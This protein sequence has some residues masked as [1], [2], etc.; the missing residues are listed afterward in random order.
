MAD[1]VTTLAIKDGTATASG[2]SAVSSSTGYSTYHALTGTLAND[3]SSSLSS[4]ST[5]IGNLL[6]GTTISASVDIITGDTNIITGALDKISSSLSYNNLSAANILNN[7]S[8]SLYEISSSINN[9]Y[10]DYY[11]IQKYSNNVTRYTTSNTLIKNGTPQSYLSLSSLRTSLYFYNATNAEV[12]LTIGSTTSYNV[13]GAY[14][15]VI[16]SSG[17]YVSLRENCRLAHGVTGSVNGTTGH[18][19]FTE[20]YRS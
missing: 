6:T 5:N 19:I 2:L 14:T 3:L 9:F 1:T 13:N 15:L 16:P 18:V 17:S 4:I 10:N 12:Y 20:I 8:S 7:I 11:D